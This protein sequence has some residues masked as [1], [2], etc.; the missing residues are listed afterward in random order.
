MTTH[1]QAEPTAVDAIPDSLNTKQMRR[2]LASSFLGSAIE[3]Y[4]FLLYATAAALV[5]GTV[6]FA[7][8]GPGMAAFASFGTLA[9]GYVARPLGGV[10]FGHFG[11]RVGRK[12]VLVVA[13][14]TMGIA[15]T[16][17][18]LLPTTAQ[19]GVVAPIL[20]VALRVVQ[21]LAVGGEWGG[22]VLM[23]LEHA[24]AR[25]RGFAASFAN[26]GGPAGALLA[27]LAVSAVTLL[28]DEQFLSWG[29]RIPFLLSI[30][31][32]LVG[33]VV[34]LK[35]AETPLFQNLEKAAES[36][37]TPLMD[38][39]TCYPRSLILAL[40]A[41]TS[42]YTIQGLVTVW[43][44]SHVVELGADK[45]GVLNAKALGA[46][47][48]VITTVIGARL[49][50]R[51]G[52]RPV[53]L[54]GA[55]AA[56][57]TAYPIL[58]LIDTGTVWGFTIAAVAAQAIQGVIFG[59]FGAFVAELFPTRMRYTGASL[60][61]QSATTLGAGF[62]PAIAAGLMIVAGGSIV[63]V[64]TVWVLAFLVAAGA[65]LLSR[66]GRDSNLADES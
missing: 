50:D 5:F 43:G 10:I 17:I 12:A 48:I 64:G 51:F 15:T 6:F 32:V 24:P 36:K 29:W 40:I 9:A 33:L 14:L 26:L 49:S 27:T 28:P 63:L 34:R 2:I 31:L 56:A 7:D 20:L 41:G 22:A 39:L 23:A 30:V 60:A 42:I 35:V 55:I 58:M 37:K 38:V 66:E 13:M 59:P 52:R 21:G 57:L 47:A 3:F 16:L 19:I 54:T 11:D 25:Q 8:L 1:S 65:I 53:M 18:G 61:F 44:V 46:V 62:T 4:D 45:T